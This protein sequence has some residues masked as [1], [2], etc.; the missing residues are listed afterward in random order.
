MDL[1][2]SIKS[3]K[4]ELCVKYK[5]FAFITFKFTLRTPSEC[6]RSHIC[7]TQSLRSCP[8]KPLIK[9]LWNVFTMTLGL[10]AKSPK[11]LVD[12]K[13]YYRIKTR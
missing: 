5:Q 8:A 1:L 11:N 4:I 2:M 9:L 13:Q 3:C 6:F 7:M 12:H 10:S